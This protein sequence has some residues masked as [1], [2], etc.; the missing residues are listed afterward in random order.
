MPQQPRAW[1]CTHLGCIPEYR[2][3]AGSVG[4]EWTGGFYCPCHGSKYDLSGRDQ[5]RRA[6]GRRG[7]EVGAQG[8]VSGG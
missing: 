2:P 7:P 5:D 8:L 1:I 6:E 4:P 3:Q